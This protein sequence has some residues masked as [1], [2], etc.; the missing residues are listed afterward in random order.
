MDFALDKSFIEKLNEI[1][2]PYFIQ[3]ESMIVNHPINCID[4]IRISMKIQDLKLSP[5]ENVIIWIPNQQ[6][7]VNLN[8]MSVVYDI[9]PE[10]TYKL[11]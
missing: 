8:K 4:N 5:Q 9:E 11:V 7:T 3:N 1:N 10:K 6:A 2:C